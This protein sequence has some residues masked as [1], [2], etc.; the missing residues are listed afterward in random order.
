MN[1]IIQVNNRM[2]KNYQYSLDAEIG[3]VLTNEFKP[4]LSP[5]ELLS[6]G[7]FGG[8][9]FND[10]LE[11]YPKDWFETAKLSGLDNPSD[12]ELNFFKVN[13]GMSLAEW[14]K[15]SWILEPDPRGWM[16]WYFRYFYG[17]RIAALD[18]KQQNR[19]K[20]IHRHITQIKN[21][22]RSLDMSCRPKQRQTLLHWAIDSR[23][24]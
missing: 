5:K 13:C 11:E 16:E 23:K 6:L 12:P 1:K 18:K 24:F 2:Q 14:R 21:N 8:K 15:R 10:C 19:W 22:C 9:Y 20:S 17:R 4:D 3:Q 7:I